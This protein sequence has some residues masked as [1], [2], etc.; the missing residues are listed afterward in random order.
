MKVEAL[1]QLRVKPL[2]EAGEKALRVSQAPA[3]QARS[4]KADVLYEGQY[5]T[6]PKKAECPQTQAAV[7]ID[8]ADAGKLLHVCQD[9]KCP[10][11]AR[12]TRYQPSPQERSARAKEALAERIEKE[13]RVRILNA[14]RNKLSTTLS[15]AD[16]EMAA[17]D[18]FE[19]LGHDNHRRLCR[20]YGWPEKKTKASWG[21]TTVDYP[22]IAGK[23][24]HEMQP[25]D[26][27]CFLVI[28]AL[29]ADLYC[30]SYNS[31][32]LLAKDSN[33]ARTAVR[34]KI[35]TTKLA[36]QVRAELS[37]PTKKATAKKGQA[38]AA[39]QT[40]PK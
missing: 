2:E 34:Y 27:Q 19:R 9:E 39:T 21:G 25:Q 12:V 29:V 24:V 15:R 30:P 17:L 13:T 10:I 14:I 35:D 22:N 37:K 32:Q 18:Y 8:G 4:R 1:V 38:K 16:L 33:L 3:W 5:R 7:V 28:C 11:H 31:R 23:A 40:K 26:L 20:V 36:A 6:V